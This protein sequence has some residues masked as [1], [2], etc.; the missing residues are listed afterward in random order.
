MPFTAHTMQVG[1]LLAN[2]FVIEVPR[3]Q[4]SYVWTAEEAGCLLDDIFLALD[5]EA[6]GEEAEYFLGTML[7]IERDRPSRLKNWPR[8]LPT[9]P[10][11]VVD[12]FQRLT[13]LTILL[14]ILRDL[15]EAADEVV[16][17]RLL[18]AIGAGQGANVRHRL[19]LK[20]PEEAFFGAYVRAP[21]ATRTGRPDAFR[22]PAE[23][24]IL[25]VRDHCLAVLAGCDTA[26]R[27]RLAAFLLERCHVVQVG[28]TDID[29]A[30][31]M[32]TVLNARGK[33]LARNDILKAELLGQVPPAAAASATAM[34]EEAESRLGAGFEQLFSHIR[35]VYGRLDDPVIAGIGR[36]ASERGGAQAF[37]EGVLRPAAAILDGIGRARHDGQPQSPA[38]SQRLRYLGWHSHS[39]W[40]PPV[41]LWWL[42]RGEDAEG[43]AA[44]LARIDRLAFAMRILGLGGSKRARRFGAVVAAI[45]AGGSLEEPDGP[46]ELTRQEQRTILH[47]L[48]DLHARNP[49]AAKHLLMRLADQKAGAPQSLSLPADMTV[50]HVLPR[51]VGAGSQWRSWHPDPEERERSTESLGNLVLVSKAQN[52][53]AGNHDFARKLEIYFGERGRPVPAINEDLRGRSEWKAA[54]IKAR[55]AQ[56][57]ALVEELWGFGPARPREPAA[58]A[59]PAAGKRG[60]RPRDTAGEARGEGRLP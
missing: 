40:V 57:M 39:D 15:E 19:S 59:R 1:Q 31:R 48:R 11:D 54:D 22:T 4:R 10:L 7:F 52:D 6:A 32:F 17:A 21:G 55:E 47:N 60:G 30:H 8:G 49:L 44:F 23:A 18:A 5:S 27:N 12:G 14:C 36:I 45:R 41:M 28:V 35:A 2:P 56:L 58:E 34:W 29:R 51:K 43:L 42:E 50:E 3:Y 25:A 37:I 26:E 33:P 9:R 24:H 53:R 38:I 13:T 20:G 46:L 16:N